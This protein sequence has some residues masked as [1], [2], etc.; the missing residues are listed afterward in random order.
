MGEAAVR[1]AGKEGETTVLFNRDGTFSSSG[2]KGD[3]F[4]S[5]K[6]VGDKVCTHTKDGGESC[7]VI[8]ANRQVGDRWTQTIDGEAIEV[9]ITAGR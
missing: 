5:W 4:G 7:G 6:I 9:T 2:P 8:Q 1:I 3:K